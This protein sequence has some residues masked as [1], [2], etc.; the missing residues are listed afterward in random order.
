MLKRHNRKREE[1]GSHQ[2]AENGRWA[3][4]RLE[5]RSANS[6]LGGQPGRLQSLPLAGW[7]AKLFVLT[8]KKMSV[9]Q[10]PSIRYLVLNIA[11]PW[12][13]LTP[14]YRTS[15]QENKL[16]ACM[17]ELTVASLHCLTVIYPDKGR[18]H[19][20]TMQRHGSCTHMLDS[21]TLP[22][23]VVSLCGRR[24]LAPVSRFEK[25][26]YKLSENKLYTYL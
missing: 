24:T 10:T 26:S 7:R 3:M 6:S 19:G 13:H 4:A 11:C 20:E 22:A 2:R 18:H 17:V 25:Q 16:L 9:P 23:A 8:R 15:K 21:P 12:P 14:R 1:R 5:C